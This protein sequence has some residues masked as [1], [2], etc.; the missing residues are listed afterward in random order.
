MPELERV[1]QNASVH[2]LFSGGDVVKGTD[3]LVAMCREEASVAVKLLVEAGVDREA[4]LGS[5]IS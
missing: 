5:A 3:V 2:A 1:L 4:V